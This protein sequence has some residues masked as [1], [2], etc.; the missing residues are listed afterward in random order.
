MVKDFWLEIICP[1]VFQESSNQKTDLWVLGVYYIQ[2][3]LEG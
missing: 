1:H 3:E 2:C